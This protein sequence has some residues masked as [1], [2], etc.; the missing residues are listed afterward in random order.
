[1]R[2]A[3]LLSMRTKL[4]FLSSR[5][6]VR[7]H[8]KLER[9]FDVLILFNTFPRLDVPSINVGMCFHLL[10][11]GCFNCFF[12]GRRWGNSSKDIALARRSSK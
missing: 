5:S 12:N 4:I 9:G 2:L 10:C 8:M 3:D 11:G 1:M 6:L 7:L